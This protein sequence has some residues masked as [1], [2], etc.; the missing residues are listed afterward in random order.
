MLLLKW[1][2]DSHQRYHNNSLLN[3]AL[4]LESYLQLP[5][6]RRL[7]EGGVDQALPIQE[8]QGLRLAY[9][10]GRVQ[11]RYLQRRRAGRLFRA[12]N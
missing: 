10:R 5:F 3:H 7:G 8:N 1:M 11:V 2:S 6:K 9:L 12:Q 4:D